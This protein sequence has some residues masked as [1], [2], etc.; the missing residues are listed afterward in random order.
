M[1]NCTIK[2]IGLRELA[3]KNDTPQFTRKFGSQTWEPYST[4]DNP[5]PDNARLLLLALA[6]EAQPSPAHLVPFRC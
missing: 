5:Q 3:L 4:L 2:R 1:E 6:R